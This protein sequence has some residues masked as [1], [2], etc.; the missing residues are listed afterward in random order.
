MGERTLI[1]GGRVIDPANHRDGPATVVVERG[2]IAAILPAGEETGE[3]DIIDASGMVVC[4]GFVDIHCH[5]RQPGL[6][7]KETI[8]SGTLAAACGGFTT[9]CC[10]PNT[11]PPIDSVAMVMALQEQIAHEAVVRVG[12]IAAI[13]MGQEGRQVTDMVALA[14]AGAIAFSDDG[15]P[16]ISPHIMRQ[17]LGLSAHLHR[18]LTVHEE[19]PLLAQSGVMNAGPTAT[20]LGLRGQPSAAEEAMIARDIS[21]LTDVPEA[22]LHICH[23]STSGSVALLRDAHRRGA[24]ITGEV[25]PHHLTLTDE[26]VARPWNGY[27]YDTRTKVNPPLRRREDVAAVIAGLRDGTLAAVATDHAPH[28]AADKLCSYDDAAFGFTV[29]ETALP[30]LLSLVHAEQLTL[31]DLIA[32]LTIKPARIFHLPA[33]SLSAGMPADITIFDP[34]H[35]WTV[36]AN[37]FASRGH[38]TPLDGEKVLGRVAWTLCGGQVVVTPQNGAQP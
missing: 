30:S 37:D 18:P 35:A 12:I 25:T 14:T 34:Q 21:L 22:E 10:M 19:D 3:G 1:Q 33:G 38:N 29:F 15:R 11:R 16:V 20:A 9:I 7:H 2:L 6:D 24:T 13:T 32:A 17:A 36:R 26:R 23:V 4:P 8:A 5:L 27:P 31:S 28:S